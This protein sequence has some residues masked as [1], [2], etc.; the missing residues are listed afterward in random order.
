WKST[1]CSFSFWTVRN[2]T[3]V[4]LDFASDLD[5]DTSWFFLP[6]TLHDTKASQHF[7]AVRLLSHGILFT[8]LWDFWFS[9][10][11]NSSQAESLLMGVTLLVYTNAHILL[12]QFPSC[13]FITPK[14]YFFLYMILGTSMCTSLPIA[15]YIRLLFDRGKDIAH[16]EWWSSY[17]RYISKF[18]VT[19]CLIANNGLIFTNAYDDKS[20]HE[21]ILEFEY[22]LVLWFGILHVFEFVIN[23]GRCDASQLVTKMLQQDYILWFILILQ[24]ARKE[25][26]GSTPKLCG[27]LLLGD[28]SLAQPMTLYTHNPFAGFRNAIYTIILLALT[29]ATTR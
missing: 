11:V 25:E 22:R 6:T 19:Y 5:L 4:D 23:E 27:R 10:T 29:V 18:Y 8:Q 14:V 9:P 28:T 21:M 3:W 17:A 20:A 24:L 13:A 7:T 12:T 15:V 26:G 1:V 2:I 16:V